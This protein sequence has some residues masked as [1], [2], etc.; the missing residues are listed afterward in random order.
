LFDF[1]GCLIVDLPMASF[2]T[3]IAIAK[4]YAERNG[5]KD[6]TSFYKGSIDPDMTD[7]K[8]TTHYGTAPASFENAWVR[9]ENKV[10]LAK[11]LEHNPIE[12]DLNLGRFLHLITDQKFFHEFLGKQS[13]INANHDI[14]SANLFHSYIAN[15]PHL[16]KK[17]NL[18]GLC[19]DK[20]MEQEIEQIHFKFAQ[21]KVNYVKQK[22]NH[23]PECIICVKK[24]DEFINEVASLDLQNIAERARKS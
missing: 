15:N 13:M 23:S 3:H 20:I 11:F 12:S 7:D 8:D 4:L 14:F 18:A 9:V 16:I 17:Y 2:N 5:I 10:D 22:Y 1:G 24:L 21:D 19:V 6:L